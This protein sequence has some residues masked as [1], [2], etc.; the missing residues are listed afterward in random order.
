MILTG[1]VN[2]IS[3][4]AAGINRTAYISTPSSRGGRARDSENGGCAGRND[5]R[6]IR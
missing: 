2:A 1:I 5:H 4:S 3:L 6:E